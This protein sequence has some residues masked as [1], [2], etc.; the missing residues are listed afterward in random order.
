MENRRTDRQGFFHSFDAMAV[1][2][3][4]RSSWRCCCCCVILSLFIGLLCA[5]RPELLFLLVTLS[6]DM[7]PRGDRP[8]ATEGVACEVVHVPTLRAMVP[9]NRAARLCWPSDGRNY[10]L[11]IVAHADY[12]GGNVAARYEPYQERLASYGLVVA[13]YYSCEITPWHCASGQLVF[14]EV[15]KLLT[16][17]ERHTGSWRIDRAANYSASGHSTGGRAMLMLAALRDA[18]EYL[19]GTPTV[20][21]AVQSASLRRLSAVIVHHGDDVHDLACN[22]DV[23]RFDVSETAVLVVTGSRDTIEPPMTGWRNF[24]SLRT[25]NKIFVDLHN[26][27]HDSIA[28]VRLVAQLVPFYHAFVRRYAVGD[29]SA[30]DLVY[31]AGPNAM[32][33]SLTIATGDDAEQGD[34]KVGFVACRS[35]GEAM[36]TEYASYCTPERVELRHWG[37][38]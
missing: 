9:Q 7:L 5:L 23:A 28:D 15:L 10:P 3:G 38:E 11:H 14:L 4:Q 35:G 8:S 36:P 17:L 21:T 31:G 2:S 24:V 34:H 19:A 37:C 25:P 32:R 29:Q 1:F 18:P 27:T 26:T 20:L 12:S 13:M 30:A 22:P 6:F 16:F 33:Q